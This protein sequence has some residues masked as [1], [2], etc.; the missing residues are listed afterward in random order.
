MV[1]KKTMVLFFLTTAL[2]GVSLAARLYQ[3]GGSAGWTSMGQVDYQDWAANKIFHSGDTLVFNYNM[4]YTCS[5][6]L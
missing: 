5:Y 4:R 3:V 2:C 1:F 6:T